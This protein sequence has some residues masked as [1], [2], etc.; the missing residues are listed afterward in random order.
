MSN[1]QDPAPG[2]R[3]WEAIAVVVGS[4]GLTSLLAVG[5][6]I[7]WRQVRKTAAKQCLGIGGVV[8]AVFW[9]V[10]GRAIF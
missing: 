2:L 7:H 6:A 3:M 9:V 5:L 10:W 1:E 8:A 4:I